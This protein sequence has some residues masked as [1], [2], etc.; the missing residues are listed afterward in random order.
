MDE[1]KNDRDGRGLWHIYM[2]PRRVHGT[3]RVLEGVLRRKPPGDVLMF[4]PSVL[5]LQK[6]LCTKQISSK[7]RK[8]SARNLTQ[9]MQSQ[10]PVLLVGGGDTRSIPSCTALPSLV[11][12]FPLCGLSDLCVCERC[13][14]FL[15]LISRL[16]PAFSLD[17]N[18]VA[19]LFF[20]WVLRCFVKYVPSEVFRSWLRWV[21]LGR[22][23]NIGKAAS[24]LK[25]LSRKH[26]L[27]KFGCPL[28]CWTALESLGMLGVSR[29]RRH[30]GGNRLAPEQ[31]T[32]KIYVLGGGH[33]NSVEAF[34]TET[35]RWTA[36]APM[37]WKRHRC[38]AAMLDGAPYAIDG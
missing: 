8:V 6:A 38:E 17:S 2:P 32:N 7:S 20:R 31:M 9:R 3:L 28:E 36:V 34:D 18:N 4:H 27:Y 22:G 14:G 21:W 24:A 11:F 12:S 37:A 30:V 5:R 13:A 16:G 33:L 10:I 1:V 35:K 19:D 26:F 23:L 29:D 25:S 15:H